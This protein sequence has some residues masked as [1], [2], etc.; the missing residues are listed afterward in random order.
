[1]KKIILITV[2][3]LATALIGGYFYYQQIR[4]N[5]LEKI[6]YG[7]NA[8]PGE[9]PYLVAYE[10]GFFKQEGLDVNLVEEGNYVNLLSDLTAGKINFSGG[11]ALIDVVAKDSQGEKLKIILATDYSDGAD[12]I[13]AKN[14]IKNVSQ[15]KGKRIAVEVG[16]LGE[17]LLYDALKKSNLNLT[18]VQIVNLSA[19]E[20]ANAFASNSVDAAVT[21]EPYYSQ[22]MKLGKGWGIYTSADSPGL[23]IDALVFKSDYV[24]NNPTKVA[25]VTRAYF[26][27]MDFI[28]ANPDAAYEIGAKYFKISAAELKAQFA[29]IKLVGL[30]GNQNLMAY[31]TNRDSLHG[32]IR[33]AGVFL[34]EKGLIRDMIDSTEII[35]PSFVREIIK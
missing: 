11:T 26:K 17:Y 33:Q 3:V 8:W 4:P 25:A 5:N 6:T 1:M 24:A 31:N 14:E 2:V 9:L 23:I 10:R 32:L 19:Q 35:D 7:W 34:K 28:A 18:D 13:I 22:V 27:A 29:T 15:L 12:G 20:S 21:Y 30:G 16:T